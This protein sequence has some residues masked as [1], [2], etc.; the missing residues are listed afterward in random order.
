MNSEEIIDELA[1]RQRER[2]WSDRELG[3]RAGV[4]HSTWSNIRLHRRGGG[5]SII[6]RVADALEAP[7]EPASKE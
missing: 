6:C 2:G 1:R 7:L 3:A 5:L 4:S